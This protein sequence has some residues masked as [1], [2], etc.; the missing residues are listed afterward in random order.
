MVYGSN[1][2]YALQDRAYASTLITH[3]KQFIMIKT[4]ALYTLTRSDIPTIKGKRVVSDAKVG[5][6]KL[7]YKRE[8]SPIL[9]ISIFNLQVTLPLIPVKGEKKVETVV[10]LRPYKNNWSKK[11]DR[12]PFHLWGKK[13]HPLTNLWVELEFDYQDITKSFPIVKAR[14][15][16]H[17]IIKNL[18]QHAE[19]FSIIY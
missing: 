11:K 15:E 16:D 6:E 19:K 12:L 5:G 8:I 2:N 1:R 18:R 4:K 17:S 3:L 9:I 7:V 10:Y 13:E 14:V